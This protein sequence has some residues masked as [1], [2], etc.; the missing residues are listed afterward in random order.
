M[1]TPSTSPEWKNKRRREIL[2]PD[3]QVAPILR[4]LFLTKFFESRIG[5]QWVPD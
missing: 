2:A 4:L 5:T 1:S 3:K